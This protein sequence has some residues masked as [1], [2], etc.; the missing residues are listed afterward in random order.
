MTN[1]YYCRAW[2]RCEKIPLEDYSKDV[3]ENR[4]R[5]REPYTVLVNSASSPSAFAEIFLKK[6]FVCVGFLDK[7]LREYISYQFKLI[8][9]ERWFLVMAVYRKYIAETEEVNSAETYIFKPEG[10]LFIRRDKFSPRESE[11]ANS[12]FNPDKNY[13]KFSGFGD[14][15]GIFK[16]ER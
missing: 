6:G 16:I 13:E 9:G 14:Y 1:F 12:N 7:L 15:Q 8:E 2:S 4:H 5:Q 11:V 3:A 10:D